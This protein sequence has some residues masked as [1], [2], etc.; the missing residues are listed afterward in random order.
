MTRSKR[1][2]SH[3]VRGLAVWPP[4]SLFPA[5]ETIRINPGLAPLLI[6]G[7][8]DMLL[9]IAPCAPP[10]L[11]NKVKNPLAEKNKSVTPGGV[12][13]ADGFSQKA[14]YPTN[15]LICVAREARLIVCRKAAGIMAWRLQDGGFQH[16][17]DMDLNVATSLVSLAVSP[18][19]RWIA[20]S[21]AVEVKLFRIDTKV[22]FDYASTIAHCMTRTIPFFDLQ[23]DGS[24]LQPVRIKSISATL[25]K[26][27]ELSSESPGAP[28]GSASQLL[29]TPDSTRMVVVCSPSS[30]IVVVDLSMEKEPSAVRTFPYA[31]QA[32]SE[33]VVKKLPGS[34]DGV[35]DGNR[36][37]PMVT[38]LALSGDG[39]WLA[40][41]DEG[42]R[43]N[44]FNMDA[45][46]VS[47]QASCSSRP[48]NSSTSPAPL[49]LTFLLP[50]YRFYGFLSSLPTNPRTRPMQ[51]PHIGFRRRTTHVPSLGQKRLR[52]SACQIH[53]AATRYRRT[54]FC[55]RQGERKTGTPRMGHEL[56]KQDPVGWS[57]NQGLV[58]ASET[59]AS[60]S[61]C[62]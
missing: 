14:P 19:G 3:D 16:V 27:L 55:V 25:L 52:P 37:P 50:P 49:Y 30:D 41:A 59:S 28:S 6:S 57:A 4:L 22:G 32:A 38:A 23:G 54:A 33:R 34:V 9:T 10:S 60:A 40:A 7:G 61:R 15:G 53:I 5:S 46:Q 31:R 39:Q 26:Q 11:S 12:T 36:P 43:V 47:T 44:V 62:G 13:L 56:D 35:R 1:V 51:Q 58:P 48:V 24:R 8:Q 45:L 20:C 29:F 17:L 2:H 42:G 18:D 21:D